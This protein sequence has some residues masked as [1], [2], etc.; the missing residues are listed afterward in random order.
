MEAKFV[1]HESNK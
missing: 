1:A